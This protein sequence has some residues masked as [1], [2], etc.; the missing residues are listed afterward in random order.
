LP[1]LELKTNY[2]I[3]SVCASAA[4]SVLAVGLVVGISASISR[5][6]V[7]VSASCLL[8]ACVQWHVFLNYSIVVLIGIEKRWRHR[9]I[10]TMI[11]HYGVMNEYPQQYRYSKLCRPTSV[12][13][14][15]FCG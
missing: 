12:L 7:R 5:N 8:Q 6:Y 15:A 9:I 2:I 11:I 1:I 13:H 14:M 3:R 10:I 4:L